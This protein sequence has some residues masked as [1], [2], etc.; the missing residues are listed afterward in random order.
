MSLFCDVSYIS[1]GNS[2]TIAERRYIGEKYLGDDV[3]MEFHFF[4]KICSGI[5]RVIYVVVLRKKI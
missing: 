5:K 4:L 3:I 2:L 1:G